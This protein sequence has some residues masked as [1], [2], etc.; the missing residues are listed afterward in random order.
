MNELPSQVLSPSSFSELFSLWNRFSDAEPVGGGTEF[1]RKHGSSRYGLSND[2]LTLDKLD[3]LRRMRRTERYLEIGA[4]V[5]LNQILNLGRIVPEPLTR[6]LE[7]IGGHQLRNL[8]TIG[9]N[10]CNTSYRHDSMAPMIALDAQYELRSA[11]SLR[12]ISASRFISHSGHLG[13]NRQEILTRIR[14]PL[15]PW[16]FVK[17]VKLRDTDGGILF[18]MKIEKNI[19]T[20]IRVVYSGQYIFRSKPSETMLE[21]KR[22]PLDRKEADAFTEGWREYISGIMDNETSEVKPEDRYYDPD[23][24]KAQIMNFIEI[25]ISGISD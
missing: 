5:K 2:I 12:W 19:L 9:G 22:L 21:G 8:A 24:I 6:C 13:L 4:M 1:I 10:I 11:S 17:Y 7:G 23:L 18:I 20:D 14:I 16:A 3:D 15:E 25:T